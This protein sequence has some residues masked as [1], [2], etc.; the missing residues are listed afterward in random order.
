MKEYFDI[1]VPKR[2]DFIWNRPIGP[3]DIIALVCSPKKPFRCS[4]FFVST[5]AELTIKQLSVG[6][7]SQLMREVPCELWNEIGPMPLQTA[8]VH[9]HITLTL[10]NNTNYIVKAFSATMIGVEPPEVMG[11]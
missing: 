1:P 3:G 10:V 6:L 11:T 4:R 5:G 2:H 8:A 9:Q 7:Y